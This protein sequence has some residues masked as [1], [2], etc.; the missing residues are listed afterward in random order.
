[1]FYHEQCTPF[2]SVKFGVAALEAEDDITRKS[3]V[4]YTD[5]QKL[6]LKI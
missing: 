4:L 2:G 1:M 6:D 3:K 5:L